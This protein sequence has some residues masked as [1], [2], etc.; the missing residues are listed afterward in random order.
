MKNSASFESSLSRFGI[1]LFETI[2]VINGKPIFIDEHM[3][4]IYD[5]IRELDINFKIS[6]DSLKEEIFKYIENEDYKALR[7][8]VFD[9]GYNLSLRNINYTCEDYINGYKINIS[10]IRRGN[11][12]IY[13]H[14]TTNYAENIYSKKYAADNGYDEAIFI[15][16]ENKILEGSM[17]NIFFIK[18]KKVYTPKEDMY[19]LPGI[20]RNEIIKII[21]DLNIQILECEIDFKE[22]HE[23]DFCFIT[24]SLVDIIKVNNIEDIQYKKENDLFNQI[25]SKLKEKIYGC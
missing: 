17:T 20:I 9:E 10:P 11:S 13:K 18:D 22:I 16:T 19:I 6:K 5:S 23:F 7:I 8:T 25:V 2:K 14:K 3:D 4:R 24:N 15:N 21:R 1:G 12:F